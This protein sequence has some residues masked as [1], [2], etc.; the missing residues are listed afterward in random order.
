MN[1]S[2]CPGNRSLHISYTLYVRYDLHGSVFPTNRYFFHFATD[3][4]SVQCYCFLKTLTD[5]FL[6]FF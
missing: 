1:F 2:V 4:C 6:F 3:L 5:S